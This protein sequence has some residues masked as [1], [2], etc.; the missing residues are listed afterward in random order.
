LITTRRVESNPASG[1]TIYANMD[2]ISMLGVGFVETQCA[3]S[4]MLA[5]RVESSPASGV[6]IYANMDIISMLG[7]GFVETQGVVFFDYYKAR[8]VESCLWRYY[9]RKHGYHFDAR[10]GIRGDAMRGHL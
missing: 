10:S 5:R 8:R 1:V 2:I 3:A 9:I 7:V 4:L 6:T